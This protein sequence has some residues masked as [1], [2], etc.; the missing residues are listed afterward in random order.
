MWPREKIRLFVDAPLGEGKSIAL[1]RDQA[2]YLFGVMRLGAGARVA[3][4]N[5]ADGEW[6]AEVAEAGKK[7]GTLSCLGRSAAQLDP[8]DLWLM[9]AP[10]K[11]A[12]T[13]FIV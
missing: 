1:G 3:L 6:T 11:K 4:F 5:G 9:F 12:R 7:G 8:P 10:I 2:H 13:D